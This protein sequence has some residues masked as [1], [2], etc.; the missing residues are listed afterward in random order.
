MGLWKRANGVEAPRLPTNWSVEAFESADKANAENLV[1]LLATYR[2]MHSEMWVVTMSGPTGPY[3]KPRRETSLP[4]AWVWAMSK[5]QGLANTASTRGFTG[6]LLR[7]ERDEA[8]V[9]L[10]LATAA[11]CGY[12]GEPGY[13]A[14]GH[15]MEEEPDPQISGL[16]ILRP[17]GPYAKLLPRQGAGA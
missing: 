2:P 7:H 11:W 12:L 3:D 15:T 17:S 9:H 4:R 14:Y 5:A 8:H 6:V 16:V 10:A 13:L 1:P